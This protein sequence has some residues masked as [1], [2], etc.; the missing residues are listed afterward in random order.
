MAS[1]TPLLLVFEPLEITVL[2]CASSPKLVKDFDFVCFLCDI[3]PPDVKHG[4]EVISS[5]E[6]HQSTGKPQVRES[7]N[8]GEQP[9]I[10]PLISA[11]PIDTV[12]WDQISI[13]LRVDELN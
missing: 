6:V 12:I 8:P 11:N 10:L 7:V 13:L 3:D 2:R 9:V 5:S 4:D 1:P